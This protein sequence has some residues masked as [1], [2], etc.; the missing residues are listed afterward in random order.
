MSSS[1][2]SAISPISNSTAN[3]TLSDL[4]LDAAIE[5]ERYSIVGREKFEAVGQLSKLLSQ[6]GLSDLALMPVYD[7]ALASTGAPA[8]VSKSDLYSRLEDVLSKMNSTAT[9]SVNELELLRDFCV[10]LHEALLTNRPQSARQ[11]Y[12]EKRRII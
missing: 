4:A 3:L 2:S 12:L 10:A 9:A 7:R 8:A 11:P 6:R 1:A 5:L